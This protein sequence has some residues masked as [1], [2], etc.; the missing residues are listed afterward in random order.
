VGQYWFRTMSAA[1]PAFIQGCTSGWDNDTVPLL[2]PGSFLPRPT[3]SV[4]ILESPRGI[5]F[6]INIGTLVSCDT[7]R[8]FVGGHSLKYEVR[9]LSRGNSSCVFR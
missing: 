9:T 2:L 5:F 1:T 6:L 4:H 7:L 8:W 3:N